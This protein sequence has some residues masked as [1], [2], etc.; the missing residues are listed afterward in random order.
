MYSP[1]FNFHPKIL[2]IHGSVKSIL[3]AD[4]GVFKG[5]QQFFGRKKFG[6]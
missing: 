1:K 5:A 4:Y 2:Q 6:F 3:Q